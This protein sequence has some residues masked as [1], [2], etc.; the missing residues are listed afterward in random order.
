MQVIFNIAKMRKVI[1]GQEMDLDNLQRYDVHSMS[2][3]ELHE[4]QNNL[5][6]HY[7]KAIKESSSQIK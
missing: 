3:N 1:T 5:I 4:L 2:Y 7:N 6:P